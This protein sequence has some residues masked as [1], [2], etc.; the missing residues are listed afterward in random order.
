MY[1][2]VDGSSSYRDT[3][4]TT[5]SV[6]LQVFRVRAC[7][8]VAVLLTEVVGAVQSHAYEI[9]IGG[10]GHV[11]SMRDMSTGKGEQKVNVILQKSLCIIVPIF[12]VDFCWVETYKT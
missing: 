5:K 1:I 9:T 3:W 12:C 11:T 6:Y 7:K 10:R 4:V 2:D 8:N